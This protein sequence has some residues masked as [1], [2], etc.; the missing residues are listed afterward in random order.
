MWLSGSSINL[1][2]KRLLVRF[3]SGHMPELRA[4]CQVGGLAKGNWTMFL[5]FSFSLSF[6]LSKNTWIKYFLEIFNLTWE[7]FVT[8]LTYAFTGIEPATL[9]C[10]DDALTNWATWLGSTIEVLESFDPIDYYCGEKKIQNPNLLL[11]YLDF[12]CFNNWTFLS[13]V[14]EK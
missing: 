7:R 13:I 1:Q 5:S 2:T 4:R 11:V 10:Q 3:W 8:P 14:T 6:T 9:A 12:F